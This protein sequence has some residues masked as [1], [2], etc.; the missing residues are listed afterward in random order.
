MTR[1]ALISFVTLFSICATLFLFSGSAVWAANS[2]ALGMS[3]TL[4]A[5]EIVGEG[6]RLLTYELRIKEQ[7][8]TARVL[9]VDLDN[10][11]AEIQAM[12]PRE[13]FNNRQ[14]LQ[15]MAAEQGA[16]AAVNADFF[17]L[18]RPAAP[19][20]LHLE[21]GEILSSPMYNHTW[22]GF[23]ID[24]QRNAHIS[25]WVF[26]GFITCDE[27]HRHELYAYNQTY[28]NGNR[29]YL[30]DHNWGRE[31]SAVFFSEPVVQVT[32]Q[33][34][35]VTRVDV[36]KAAAP[37]PA[38]GFVLIAAGDSA[39][40]LLQHAPLGS[41]ITYSLGIVPEMNLDTSVGGHMLLVENGRAVD[42]GRLRSP[43]A[44][45]AA[46]T[47][48][49]IDLTGKK[50]FF[51][52]VDGSTLL[53]GVTMEE[54]AVFLSSLDLG[55]DRAL[56]LDGGGST[57][58]V[59]R[60]LGEHQPD[61]INRPS[62]GLQ[63]TL[64]N[65]IGVFNR[66]PR[67]GAAKLFLWGAEGLLPGMEAEY[68]VTGHDR[69]YHPLQIL[70]RDLSW[71]VSDSAVA[72]VAE[73]TLKALQPGEIRLRAS[74]QGVSAEK[75]V[76]IYG[77]EDIQ[78]I[79]V[80]PDAIRL[81]PGQRIPL[82]V[83]V[84]TIDGRT[85][86]AG[87][88]TVTWKADLGYVKDNIYHAEQEGFGTLRAEI[89]G[90]E[91]TV[92]LRIGGKVEPFFT[93]REWQTTVF[94]GHPSDLPGNFEIETDPRYIYRGERSGRLEY[95]FSRKEEGMMIAY[96]QLGSGQISMS[97]YVLG[98]SA[99][100]YGDNSHYWLRAELF[101]A[102]GTRRYVDLAPEVDWTGWRQVQGLVDPAWPQPLIF[103]S[104]YLVR[105]PE[106][107]SVIHPD[108]GRIYIDQVE[109]IKGLEAEDRATWE[110]NGARKPEPPPPQFTDIDGHWGKTYLL[111]LVQAGI[112]QG[113]GD[114]T[115][116]PDRAVTRAEY[117]ALLQRVFWQD[118]K[119]V[120][121]GAQVFRDAIPAWAAG[122]VALGVEKGVVRGY[123]DGT[124]R[125]HNPI[126]RAEMATMTNLALRA[127]ETAA[128]PDIRGAGASGQDLSGELEAIFADHARIPSWAAEHVW[129]L[130]QQG[131]IQGYAGSFHPAAQ[132]TRAEAAVVFWKILN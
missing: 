76:F 127:A 62:F 50:V 53:S 56:N 59:A 97:K 74:Y 54:L 22:L 119:G 32:V 65:G 104:I 85:L 90:F 49:G 130:Q 78:S 111:D 57:T 81:L 95:D 102:G 21:T 84:K 132:A 33:H 16:V 100:I 79:S 2:S 107:R 10:P 112:L 108:T 94:R 116:R 55:I 51:V 122:A 24:K 123:E 29:I 91:T 1:R 17:H 124:F 131:L 45:R 92:P 109:M 70:P 60:R 15:D 121:S 75:T 66:A 71:E 86:Q 44:E 96:G 8:T 73:G 38:Q 13:G 20:G 101:D 72:E 41:R 35:F 36:S 26:N 14:A 3:H 61:L 23:G 87:P 6:S 77:K 9:A 113:Y 37:I 39:D 128:A 18:N 42:A 12:S 46:R 68:R 106:M 47:A 126:T 63:R 5:E 98:V 129:E 43:G 69:H 4:K 105:L 19:F 110:E 31:V 58:L 125:P 30:Y 52:T 117:L 103:S 118:S 28:Q 67:T 48:V 88:S 99:Y 93:F 25:N 89:A 83:E 64:P 34:G 120:D 80:K 115:V 82:Q 40:F 27:A 11:Y 7:S 114:K